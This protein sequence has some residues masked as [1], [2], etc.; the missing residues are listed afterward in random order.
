MCK[1]CKTNQS[2]VTIFTTKK[3]FSRLEKYLENADE[4][5]VILKEDHESIHTFLKRVEH[6]CNTHIDLLFINTFQVSCFHLPRY[7]GFHPNCKTILTVHTANAWL[8]PKPVFYLKQLPRTLDSNLS[9]CIAHKFILPTFDAINVIY[10][11][12]KDYV[13]KGTRYE[14]EVFTLPFG[15]FNEHD[16]TKQKHHKTIQFVIPGQIEEHRRHYEIILDTFERLFTKYNEYIELF[17]LGYPVG[18]YGNRILKRCKKMKKKGYHLHYYDS[19][20]PETTYNEVMNAIDFILLPI[21][22]KTRGMGLIPEYYGITKGSAAVFEGIQYAKPLIVPKNFNILQE[23]ETSTLKF[24]DRKE[25][26][27]ILIDLINNKQQVKHLKKEAYTN[28]MS[29]SLPSIQRYFI[30]EIL[31]T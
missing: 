17:L 26:E 18:M 19:F 29:F 20:V 11:P 8:N 1:I 6:Y 10:S 25:L 15:L 3:L 16:I 2:Q 24:N 28:S 12:I 4:Y 27:K 13:K 9:A 21:R 30:K 5:T 31:Q 14:K 23:L 7:F 22:I